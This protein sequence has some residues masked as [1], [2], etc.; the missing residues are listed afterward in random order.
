MEPQEAAPVQEDKN[1]VSLEQ[2]SHDNLE[3]SPENER[4]LRELDKVLERVIPDDIFERLMVP[5]VRLLT[6]PPVGLGKAT[7]LAASAEKGE[8]RH[9]PACEA[10][11]DFAQKKMEY[12]LYETI[13]GADIDRAISATRDICV[14]ARLKDYGLFILADIPVK[15]GSV[16][17]MKAPEYW[18]ASRVA[19]YAQILGVTVEEVLGQKACSG[20]DRDFGA[21]FVSNFEDAL[22]DAGI[23]LVEVVNMFAHMVNRVPSNVKKSLIQS[24][25]MPSLDDSRR[26]MALTGLRMKDLLM[27]DKSETAG[28]GTLTVLEEAVSSKNRKDWLDAPFFAKNLRFLCEKGN[29]TASNLL[30]CLGI[31]DAR[32]RRSIMKYKAQPDVLISACADALHIPSE[33]LTTVDLTKA[34]GSTLSVPDIGKCLTMSIRKVISDAG[35]QESEVCALANTTAC[36]PSGMNPATLH[37]RLE[38]PYPMMVSANDAYLTALLAAL[39]IPSMADLYGM[40]AENDFGPK[41]QDVDEDSQGDSTRA[42]AERQENTAPQEAK[43]TFTWDAPAQI[44]EGVSFAA[45]L[46]ANMQRVQPGKRKWTVAL[47]AKESKILLPHTVLWYA[48]GKD[49]PRKQREIDALVQAFFPEA[50]PET[51]QEY[52]DK[53]FASA[54]G[55]A[56]VSNRQMADTA[57]HGM[58]AEGGAVFSTNLRRLLRK[59]ELNIPS[60]AERMARL[61]RCGEDSTLGR[62]T[63][64]EGIKAKLEKWQWNLAPDEGIDGEDLESLATIFDVSESE[65]TSLPQSE[66]GKGEI[67]SELKKVVTFMHQEQMVD[68]YFQLWLG[69]MVNA[70]S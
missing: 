60:V 5:M 36:A 48:E 33:L 37:E 22:D 17:E 7:A 24:R 12:Q 51:M 10:G 19:R 28:G 45:A 11:G 8:Q 69:G 20:T 29:I 46:Q 44:P 1:I 65:L 26:L 68:L 56:V 30:W 53:F 13:S 9:C 6:E 66:A 41:A 27:W 35:M 25:V 59:K 54:M 61:E 2:E 57:K 3:L 52:R 47:L 31:N 4:A 42:L 62:T 18:E 67:R 16:S 49:T 55:K 14:K 34:G 64:L 38:W 70:I 63:N 40:R 43:S 21:I 32:R 23:D 50:E 39:Q 58:T 15:I